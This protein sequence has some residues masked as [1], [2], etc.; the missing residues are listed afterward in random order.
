MAL[1]LDNEM[2]K[3]REDNYFMKR[4]ICSPPP[5]LPERGIEK[6]L[7][8]ERMGRVNNKHGEESLERQVEFVNYLINFFNSAKKIISPEEMAGIFRE[9]I[10]KDKKMI[11]EEEKEVLLSYLEPS[12]LIEQNYFGQWGLKSWPEIKPRSIKD[13]IYLALKKEKRP[14]HF[15]EIAEAINKICQDKRLAKPQT[16]HNELI[17]DERCVLI[18]RG[19]YAL[20]EWGYQSGIVKEVIAKILK[21]KGG[22]MN[23]DEIIKEVLGQRQVKKNTVIVNLKN[24]D[25]FVR[26]DAG[27]Y[28]LKS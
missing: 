28:G 27:K 11:A 18:G 25:C 1:E 19:I 9:K 23:R 10:I 16:V 14:L 15:V 24:H 22:T 8:R 17:K 20:K 2:E 3:T 13:K 26:L 12:K 4:W 7:S 5:T 6:V 21:G